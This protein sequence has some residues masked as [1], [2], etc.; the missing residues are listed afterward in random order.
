MV[1]HSRGVLSQV[2]RAPLLRKHMRTSFAG[3]DS[4][5][6]PVAMRPSAALK[7][8]AELRQNSVYESGS[9]KEFW[10]ESHAITISSNVQI[11]PSFFERSSSELPVSMRPSAAMKEVARDCEQCIHHR[12][13]W[14]AFWLESARRVRPA[15]ALLPMTCSSIARAHTPVDTSLTSGGGGGREPTG[16]R[17]GGPSAIHSAYN[18]RNGPLISNIPTMSSPKM[19]SPVRLNTL[20][21]LPPRGS[22]SLGSTRPRS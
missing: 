11:L 6:L 18:P 15:V 22:T 8:L 14:K 3:H 19:R 10:L 5:Q 2:R 20:L 7:A 21:P 13:S 1:V 4:S 16:G 12:P 9:W 17:N